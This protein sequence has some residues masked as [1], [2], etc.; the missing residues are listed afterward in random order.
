M[1]WAKAADGDGGYVS[2]SEPG[3]EEMGF[4]E[5]DSSSNEDTE[6]VNAQE[7][8]LHGS[9]ETM[10]DEQESGSVSN[11]DGIFDES[12]NNHER[13]ELSWYD[14]EGENDRGGT[15]PI[16]NADDYA[17]D[18]DAFPDEPWMHNALDFEV[19]IV[20]FRRRRAD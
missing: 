18:W 17:D 1:K 12:W 15:P 5:D 13:V 3:N 11:P 9:Q 7:E 8:S 20:R 19:D 10:H 6:N 14:E 2:D 16:F 4:N